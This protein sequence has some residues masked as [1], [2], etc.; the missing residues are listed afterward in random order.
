M[1]DASNTNTHILQLLTEEII[2]KNNNIL[3]NLCSK[4]LFYNKLKEERFK[5]ITVRTFSSLCVVAMVILLFPLSVGFSQE[6]HT[7]I[8]IR[9]DVDPN[10]CSFDF[11]SKRLGTRTDGEFYFSRNRRLQADRGD[12]TP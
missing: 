6:N 7:A 12:L 3:N 1:D 11:T 8:L 2:R 5:M 9:E 4:L 10:K